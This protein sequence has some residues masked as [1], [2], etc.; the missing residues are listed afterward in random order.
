LGKLH[1][2][3]AAQLGWLPSHPPRHRWTRGQQLPLLLAHGLRPHGLAVLSAELRVEH[4]VRRDDQ[5]LRRAASGAIIALLSVILSGCE[6]IESSY[7]RHFD[8]TQFCCERERGFW[9]DAR[10]RCVPHDG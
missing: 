6:T 2:D 3:H 7:C 8:G 4:R 1:A 10:G 9:D 5:L